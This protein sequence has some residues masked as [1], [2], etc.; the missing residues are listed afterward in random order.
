M[1]RKVGKFFQFY[2]HSYLM[3]KKIENHPPSSSCQ[4]HS[5]TKT[6]YMALLWKRGRPQRAPKEPPQFSPLSAQV[7]AMYLLGQLLGE[8][9]LPSSLDCK[10]CP[11]ELFS[12]EFMLSYGF[13]AASGAKLKAACCLT[14]LVIMWSGW[15]GNGRVWGCF[16]SVQQGMGLPLL[17]LSFV[18][19]WTW[20]TARAAARNAGRHGAGHLVQVLILCRAWFSL[21]LWVKPC[22]LLYMVPECDPF[23]R[24]TPLPSLG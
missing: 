4:G 13:R 22:K 24:V 16:A 14:T 21:G 18:T 12:K 7:S 19:A 1:L 5:S 23:H 9:S 6:N 11:S 2:L 15:S 10:L 3:D 17:F 8:W 20:I